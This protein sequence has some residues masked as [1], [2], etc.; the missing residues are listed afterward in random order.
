MSTTYQILYWRDIPAQVRVFNGKR[1]QSR[2]MPD[3]FQ[4]EIDRVAMAEGLAGRDEY[5]DHW[6]WTE[7]REREGD[8]EEV[9][10]AL[11]EELQKEY[12]ERDGQVND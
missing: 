4:H 10:G 7:K 2:P 3:R 5:L 9:L 1:P 6:Q 8:V 12:D 11:L